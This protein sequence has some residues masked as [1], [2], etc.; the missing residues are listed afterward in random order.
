MLP[1]DHAEARDGEL[2]ELCPPIF[3]IIDQIKPLFQSHP[4][5]ALFIDYGPETTEFGDTLQALKRHKKIG[6]FDLPGESDLTARVN[7]GQL[8]DAAT[9]SGLAPSAIITQSEL[10]SKLG[11][12]MRAVTLTR[13]KPDAKPKIIRQLRRLMDSEEMGQLFKA[14]CISANGL[15]SPLGFRA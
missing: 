8:K 7:F 13:S 1:S 5:R 9:Q 14:I 2:I 15:P 3:Q 10:L 11:I 6:V 4:G 12:E